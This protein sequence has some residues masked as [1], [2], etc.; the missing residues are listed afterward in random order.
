MALS[1][2]VSCYPTV[3]DMEVRREE[4]KLEVPRGSKAVVV[5]NLY[6]SCDTYMRLLR[7]RTADELLKPYTPGSFSLITNPEGLEHTDVPLS[8]YLGILA[9]NCCSVFL[10]GMPVM[11]SYVGFYKVCSAKKGETV[12]VSA[13]AGAIG[14]IVGRFAKLMGCYVVGCAGSK[15]KV[16]MLKNTCFPEGIDIYFN[17]VEG[18]MLEA[19]LLNMKVR[20]RI[21]LCGMVSPYSSDSHERVTN[22][23]H[24]ICKRV[25]IEGFAV[26]D[27]FAAYP[28]FLEF[29]L[30][31]IREGKI[32][33]IE[34]TAEGLDDGP[35]AL[36]RLLNGGNVGKQLV[37]VARE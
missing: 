13:A 5:K 15:E 6:L 10:F 32:V 7:N 37:E 21:A 20:H 27:H 24:A 11:T 33:Y 23:M 29:L 19:V 14:Q 35:S 34:D 8:Y 1:D 2:Y 28:K 36:F 25:R 9:D 3:D 26:Y 18:K 16:D 31:H 30:P 17:N 4:M 12:F 22:L